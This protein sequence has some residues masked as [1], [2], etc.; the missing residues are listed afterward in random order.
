MLLTV[1]ALSSLIN[2]WKNYAKTIKK[3]KMAKTPK[4][5]I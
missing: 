5:K 2:Q 1:K 4:I 3:N